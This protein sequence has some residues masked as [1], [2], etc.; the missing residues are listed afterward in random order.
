MTAKNN[1]TTESTNKALL[2]KRVLIGTSIGLAL[3]LTFV[4]RVDNPKAEW[5]QF[6]IIR[7]LIIT[8]LAGAAAGLCNHLLDILRK[9]GEGK[10][11]LANV[12]AVI[13]YV[14]GLW[15]GVVLGLAGTLWN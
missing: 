14:V 2:V 4:L 10:K 12:L 1:L 5:G 13:I 7:P 8:P 3:I 15:L 11:L 6:W 9:E